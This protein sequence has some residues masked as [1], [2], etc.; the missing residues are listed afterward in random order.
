MRYLANVAALPN[1]DG[2]WEVV[3]RTQVTLQIN[4]R[5]L[6][7]GL[8]I[9]VEAVQLNGPGLAQRQRAILAFDGIE[10]RQ[11]VWGFGA[12]DEP[13]EITL[14]LRRR[15]EPPRTLLWVNVPL[16]TNEW[17]SDAIAEYHG[18]PAP[19]PTPSPDPVPGRDDDVMI[20]ALPGAADLL[21]FLWLRPLSARE[22][23]DATRRYTAA[24][25]PASLPFYAQL[26]AI[27]GTD[28]AKQKRTAAQ[29]FRAAKN[30]PA[31]STFIADPASLPAPNNKLAGMRATLLA[32]EGPQ[33]LEA[34]T[35]A[36]DEFLGQPVKTFLA[37]AT[38]YAVRGN[39]W[40]SVAALALIGE[41]GDGALAAQLVDMLR[42]I[43]YLSTLANDDPALT[44]ARGR[45]E[46]L[47]ATPALPD[48][49]S[50]GSLTGIDG[51]PS[52]LVG[53][54]SVAGIGQLER[55]RHHLRGYAA[56]ELAEV[57]NVMPRER[58][59][60]HER[61]RLESERQRQ[62]LDE[63]TR[64]DDLS[65]QSEAANELADIVRE[66]MC[67]EGLVRN[68]QDVTPKYGELSLMLNGTA[69]GSNARLQFDSDNAARLMQR[70]SEQAAQ[71]MADRVSSQRGDVWREWRER[72]ESQCIDNGDGTRLVGIYRWVDRLMQVWL[73]DEGRRLVLAVLIETPAQAWIKQVA[74]SGMVH[75]V[76][77]VA[78][79]AFEIANGQGYVQVSPTN[80]QSW[81]AQ[82][83]LSDLPAPPD[84]KRLVSA[85]FDRV[86]IADNSQLRVPDGYEL[87]SGTV[88][89]ALADTGFSLAVNVGGADLPVHPAS[90]PV[91]DPV[92]LAVPDA[93]SSKQVANLSV[94]VPA[95]ATAWLQSQPLPAS[96]AGLRG[97]VAVTLM[98]NA[99][100]FGVT[101]DLVCTRVRWTDPQ[102]GATV[103]PL[104]VDWQM[105]IYNRLL[106]AWQA[107]TRA[108][109]VQ[110]QS[111]IETA[112]AGQ[113]DQVQRD[114]LRRQCLAILTE[115]SATA[116][117]ERL[118]GLIEWSAMS[119]QYEATPSGESADMPARPAGRTLTEPASARLF[120]RFLEAQRATV[121][122]PVQPHLQTELL[123]ALQW[124][125]CWPG[126]PVPRSD[127]ARDVPVAQAT[128][129]LLEEQRS[130]QACAREQ[131]RAWTLR[132]PLPLIYLQASDELPSF[133]AAVIPGS[134]RDENDPPGYCDAAA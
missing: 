38:S 11:V 102:G 109:E 123:Y 115:S 122:L 36:A 96:V 110:L 40:Q 95:P 16:K 31:D 81:G 41:S 64:S 129:P 92:I 24:E 79:P 62:R 58:Q 51:T 30:P 72:R 45:R 22:A 8:R 90:S 89:A 105:R 107:R 85:Q 114:A 101:V 75:L 93:S 134:W 66:V 46:L 88:T 103:D 33:T 26:A 7:D 82:Y 69:A 49:A 59:E 74:A 37:D 117:V 1:R 29:D 35:E 113:A 27:K 15:G 39:V 65:S 111:R 86:T 106:D 14:S 98:T 100:L 10:R 116:D 28:S 124:Q 104:L 55:V 121:L 83:G 17:Y 125:S 76:A 50:A 73:R 91:P 23:D 42:T 71:K 9:D 2:H 4:W 78:L 133:D 21:P 32:V 97:A 53:R 130:Q 57:V 12:P 60:R 77:P 61:S 68:L 127:Y 19:T 56:G 84:D 119:W 25:D 128:I 70:V 52:A 112:S 20:E 54:W 6:D 120:R 118:A 34:L 3:A 131:Q 126:L 48:S 80:Y 5:W 99:P 67:A 44:E 63:C 13:I 108:Y 87:S 132:L 94:N 47:Q 43:R 18:E